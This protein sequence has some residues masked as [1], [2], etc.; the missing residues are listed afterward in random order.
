[1]IARAAIDPFTLIVILFIALPVLQGIF[2]KKQREEQ[3]RRM[4]ERRRM[5]QDGRS[6]GSETGGAGAGTPAGTAMRT[7]RGEPESATDLV[8]DDLWELLTGER[9]QRTQD[10]VPTREWDAPVQDVP[11]SSS[12]AESGPVAE[13]ASEPEWEPIPEPA[14]YEPVSE[15]EEEIDQP[16][17]LSDERPARAPKPAPFPEAASRALP[18]AYSLEQ[19]ALPGDV[20]D[21][22]FHEELAHLSP[23]ARAHRRGRLRYGLGH[24]DALRRAFIL[25]EVLGPPKAL[26]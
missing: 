1:M 2:G 8:P 5:Q 22:M 15:R 17:R 23:P 6:R 16:W 20:R 12:R 18:E 11:A 4:E 3:R 19:P 7:G 21:R 24:T 13:P 26:E 25:K 10:P 14:P 9:R